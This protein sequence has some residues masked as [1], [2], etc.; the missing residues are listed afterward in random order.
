M[1]A[2]GMGWPIGMGAVLALTVAAN[3]V[4]YRVA[5]DD[6][7]FAIEPDYYRKAVAWDSTLARRAESA[8]LGWQVS[9]ALS[10]AGDALTLTTTVVDAAG[11]PLPGAAVTAEAFA[12]ARSQHPETVTLREIAPGRYAATLRP[13]R[14]G[15]W[16]VRTQ[17]TRDGQRFAAVTR[18]DLTAR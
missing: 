6:P 5:N 4:V 8:A 10:A 2:K 16:E 3:I 13:G 14:A 1:L 11:A 12:I 9:P 17:V 18:V 15:V 7:A